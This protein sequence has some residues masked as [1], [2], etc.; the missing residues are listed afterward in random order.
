MAREGAVAHLRRGP[1]S[2]VDRLTPAEEQERGMLWS[3]LGKAKRKYE[4]GVLPHYVDCVAAFASG[5][6]RSNSMR[7]YQA[8]DKPDFNYRNIQKPQINIQCLPQKEKHCAMSFT[9]IANIAVFENLISGQLELPDMSNASR[10]AMIRNF[11]VQNPEALVG[12]ATTPRNLS[13]LPVPWDEPYDPRPTSVTQPPL[14]IQQTPLQGSRHAFNVYQTQQPSATVSTPLVIPT[15]P[16]QNPAGKREKG[17]R[18][19]TQMD[20]LAADVG[21][22]LSQLEPP[23]EDLDEEYDSQPFTERVEIDSLDG[24]MSLTHAWVKH[25]GSLTDFCSM[26]IDDHNAEYFI[27]KPNLDHIAASCASI[28]EQSKTLSVDHPNRQWKLDK[29]NENLKSLKEFIPYQLNIMDTWF[30]IQTET[31]QAALSSYI[32]LSTITP[33]M[34]TLPKATLQGHRSEPKAPRKLEH[35]SEP[36][37]PRQDGSSGSGNR[38]DRSQPPQGGSSGRSH[39]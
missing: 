1:G 37:L 17:K 20:T 28:D 11:V 18:K 9:T 10:Y 3:E 31:N 15:V 21:F 34:S 13:P 2:K 30:R 22:A 23:A 4:R 36:K 33:A 38:K 39:H 5:R 29:L 27:R 7:S 25:L 32:N 12:Y 26:N 6:G 19:A 14:L 24:W 35:R 16:A 8:D